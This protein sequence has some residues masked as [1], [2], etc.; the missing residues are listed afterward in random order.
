[1][2]NNF[3]FYCERYPNATFC[4]LNDLLEDLYFQFV[5]QLPHF[6]NDWFI[7]HAYYI[8]ENE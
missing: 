8:L 5:V 7:S 3:D 4:I 1:M 2:N 6:D